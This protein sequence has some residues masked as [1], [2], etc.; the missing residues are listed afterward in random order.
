MV[1]TRCSNWIEPGVHECVDYWWG[2]EP[3]RGWGVKARRKAGFL[4]FFPYFKAISK[5]MDN[6]YS[7]CYIGIE[8]PIWPCSCEIS[9]SCVYRTHGLKV[10]F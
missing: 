1:T 7:G 2:R 4:N 9:C 8:E 5:K 3:G 10:L 6:D